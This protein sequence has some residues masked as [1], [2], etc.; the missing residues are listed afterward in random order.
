MLGDDA[1]LKRGKPNPDVFLLAAA[2][3]FGLAVGPDPQT[4]VFDPTTVTRGGT[5][6]VDE[7]LVFEDGVP[8]V[9]AAVSA[10]MPTVWVPDRALVQTLGG[11]EKATRELAPSEVLGSL[12]EFKPEAWGLPGY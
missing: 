7:V 12:E 11:E 8:G 2:A 6:D 3:H 1:R 10:G 4:G 9:Q 5:V